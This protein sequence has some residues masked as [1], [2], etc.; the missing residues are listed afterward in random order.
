M[1]QIA[2]PVIAL[3][4]IVSVVIV[5]AVRDMGNLPFL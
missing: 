4:Q 5:P 1:G 3:M 2:R